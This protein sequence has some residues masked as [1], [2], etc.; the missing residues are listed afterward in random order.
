MDDRLQQRLTMLEKT[1]V[2]LHQEL[3]SLRGVNVKNSWEGF[4]KYQSIEASHPFL[5]KYRIWPE[6][7]GDVSSDNANNVLCFTPTTYTMFAGTSSHLPLMAIRDVKTYARP[8]IVKVLG[9]LDT[10]H[11]VDLEIEFQSPEA[12]RFFHGVLKDGSSKVGPVEYQTFVHVHNPSEFVR[13][14][15]ERY[16][17]TISSWDS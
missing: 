15:T 3:L 4:V 2:D 17:R 8:E 10:R 6:N 9:A 7:I 5:D 14:L 12:E 16:K 13:F 1:V 11:R